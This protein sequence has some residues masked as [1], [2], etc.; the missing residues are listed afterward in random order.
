MNAPDHGRTYR[1][2]RGC[3]CEECRTAHSERC[4]RELANRKERLAVDSTIRPHGDTNTY[5]NWGC[6]CD[7][8]TD[9][10]TSATRKARDQRPH[11]NK[12]RR[13]VMGY[14]P[15][16]HMARYRKIQPFGRE[17]INDET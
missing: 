12:L 9:A 3:R 16:P 4:A 6:R 15:G 5:R 1:Y 8:C 11:G 7:L 17:W 13:M 10:Y 2:D 14:D